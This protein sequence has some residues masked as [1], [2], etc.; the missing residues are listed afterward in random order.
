MFKGLMSLWL[1]MIFATPPTKNYAYRCDPEWRAG[2][3]QEPSDTPIPCT[4]DM[5]EAVLPDSFQMCLKCR[6]AC[7]IWGIPRLMGT[8]LAQVVSHIADQWDYG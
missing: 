1:L 5:Q 4:N 2:H 6:T 3:L 8:T 7:D